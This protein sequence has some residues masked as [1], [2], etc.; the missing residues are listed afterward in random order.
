MAHTFQP[1]DRVCST[2]GRL[3]VIDG[4]GTVSFDRRHPEAGVPIVL[5]C[6]QRIGDPSLYEVLHYAGDAIDIFLDAPADIDIQ[7][8]EAMADASYRNRHGR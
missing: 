3:G 6:Y 1:G 5:V 4:V 8:G 7:P 2:M